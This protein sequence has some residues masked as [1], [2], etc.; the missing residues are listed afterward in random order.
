M[1]EQTLAQVPVWIFAIHGFDV[2]WF[3]DTS[4]SAN[5][6]N[7]TDRYDIHSADGTESMDSGHPHFLKIKHLCDIHAKKQ[8]ARRKKAVMD[9][10]GEI[11]PTRGIKKISKESV[12]ISGDAIASGT[13]KKLTPSGP[14]KVP[15]AIKATKG[16]GAGVPKQKILCPVHHGAMVYDANLGY[17]KCPDTGCRK[18][19]KAPLSSTSGP[20]SVIKGEP[21]V[22]ASQ[23]DDGDWHYHLHYDAANVVVELPFS[24]VLGHKVYNTTWD[25]KVVLNVMS[26][27]VVFVDK[28]GDVIPVEK[29]KDRS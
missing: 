4:F 23:D 16:V 8:Q 5:Q 27:D 17:W 28:N 11:K 22:I 13:I 19:K 21:R 7:V 6:M 3:E 29:V 12:K 10:P 9:L 14:K 18:R 1:T 24:A 20:A 26:K 15:P 25:S 2:Y